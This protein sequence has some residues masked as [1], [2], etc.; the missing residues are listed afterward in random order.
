MQMEA[1][2]A[3]ASKYLHFFSV[4]KQKRRCV[5]PT[6]PLSLILSPLHSCAATGYRGCH[7][8]NIHTH[9]RPAYARVLP[10]GPQPQSRDQRPLGIRPSILWSARC[11]QR[12]SVDA[13]IPPPQ[14]ALT[15]HQ[16]P[17]FRCHRAPV[18]PS[19][20]NL[21]Q[22][23]ERWNCTQGVGKRCM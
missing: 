5:L 13:C 14:T 6:H 7:P 3:A 22:T 18:E 8:Y 2:V 17:P 1:W 11:L 20:C 12:H 19:C 21:C 16:P 15:P 10:R 23:A 4:W 9:T